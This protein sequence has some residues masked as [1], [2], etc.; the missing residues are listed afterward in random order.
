LEIRLIPG[1]RHSPHI[2]AKQATIDAISG[3][4]RTNLTEPPP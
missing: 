4:A 3:F 1:A 2:E